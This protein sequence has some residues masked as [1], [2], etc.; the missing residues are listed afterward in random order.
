MGDPPSIPRPTSA[1]TSAPGGSTA[2]PGGRNLPNRPWDM[3]PAEFVTR[4][5]HIGPG[6][7]P[8]CSC[9]RLLAS[10]CRTGGSAGPTSGKATMDSDLTGRRD[11]AH[12]PIWKSDGARTNSQRSLDRRV[13][14]AME[15][16]LTGTPS[17]R[18]PSKVRLHRR[19][20]PISSRSP[21]FRQPK[22]PPFSP[23]RC[24]SPEDDGVFGILDEQ[25]AFVRLPCWLR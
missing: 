13:G 25:A 23:S 22:G 5:N 19:F 3:G 17:N 20:S 1:R 6:G 9:S 14:T 10:S 15:S 4:F 8:W 24:M 2:G 21:I 11:R 7:W 18:H 12:L 16:D